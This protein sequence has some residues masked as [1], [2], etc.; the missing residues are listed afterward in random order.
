VHR[1]APTSPSAFN[2]KKKPLLP[3]CDRH[4][5]RSLA[6][7]AQRQPSPPHSGRGHSTAYTHRHFPLPSLVQD[8]SDDPLA[9]AQA[10]T[11]HMP[12]YVSLNNVVR[13]ARYSGSGSPSRSAW[14]VEPVG[15][16]STT[17]IA[18]SFC[19]R[20]P[21]SGS[22][23]ASS[24]PAQAPTAEARRAG[25]G[26]G[27]CPGVRPPPSGPFRGKFP[28]PKGDLP[29][30]PPRHAPQPAAPA[31]RW[32]SCKTKPAPRLARKNTTVICQFAI[33]SPACSVPALPRH[34][35][36]PVLR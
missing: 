15:P 20:H 9:L 36:A 11:P 32:A 25:I 34:P 13:V 35:S 17:G 26:L 27:Y 7:G 2:H 28:G 14:S 10:Q 31:L 21:G 1:Y 29:P 24:R 19:V 12:Q 3:G 5:S 30:P 23:S 16:A 33:E 6:R 18:T 4:P 8:C 22:G